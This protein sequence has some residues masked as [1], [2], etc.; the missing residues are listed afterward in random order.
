MKKRVTER[1]TDELHGIVLEYVLRQKIEK[2]TQDQIA[3]EMGL[4]RH[5]LNHAIRFGPLRDTLETAVLF[6]EKKQRR[7]K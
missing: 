4:H 3:K 7:K 2:K 6:I 5:R 1:S